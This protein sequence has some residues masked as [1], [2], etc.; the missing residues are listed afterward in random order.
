[1]AKTGDRV[2]AGDVVVELHYRD[3]ARLGTALELLQSAC[4]IE[5]GPPA[6]QELIL[7]TIR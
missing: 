7:E 2:R 5:D 3:S 6:H 4:Q 1:M